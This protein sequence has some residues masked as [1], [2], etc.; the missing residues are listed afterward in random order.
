M[1]YFTLARE[2]NFLHCG[3]RARLKRE[4]DRFVPRRGAPFGRRHP[5]PRFPRPRPP[6]STR[7][8]LG[9]RRQRLHRPLAHGC[10]EIT[11]TPTAPGNNPGGPVAFAAD[12]TAAIAA[13][14][15]RQACSGRLWSAAA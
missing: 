5:P 13:R 14:L 1:R 2:G 12:G 8:Y 10:R 15:E 7:P 9:G 4:L 11:A 6:R 3:I